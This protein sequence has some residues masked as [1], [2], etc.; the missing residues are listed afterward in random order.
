VSDGREQA[1]L[2]A[3]I[4]R[5]V[6]RA[7]GSE[8]KRIEPLPGA[9]GLRAFARV[10]TGLAQPATLIARVER[11]EDPAGRPPGIPPEPALEPIRALLERSGLPVPRRYGGDPEAG[12]DLL[13]DLGDVC[14][15][16]VAHA[17]SAAERGALYRE[18]CALIP[19]LQRVADPG[20]VAAFARRLDAPYFRYK[21]RLFCEHSLTAGG[22]R[23][24]AARIACVERAFEAV[25]G[26]A[27]Q[28][29][30]RLAHRDLQSQNVLVRA[31]A[32][33]GRRLCLIDLQGALLAP[34]EYDLVCLLR[35][36][37]VELPPDEIDRHFEET[38]SALPDAPET[39][40]A[41]QRFDAL[42]LTRKGKDH[43]RF[44]YA[45]SVRGDRRYLAHLPA[46]QRH[47]QAAAERLAA[48][49]PRFEELAEIVHDLPEPTCAP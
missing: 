9:L 46:T 27:A 22:R 11:P 20:G 38:R 24:G 1:E 34:P 40:L 12:V 49:D 7:L 28:A 33:P 47:L 42:T 35:D 5:V 8:P 31:D 2:E 17:A 48:G 32:A 6:A 23:P 10:T 43:A 3:L 25:A 21:A 44:L 4:R 16:D 30:Q 18:A 39:A 41:R 14:L 13:E 19:A 45:A 26:L 36:S 15:A 37:Y 29:P